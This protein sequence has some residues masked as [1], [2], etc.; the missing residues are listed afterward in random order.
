MERSSYECITSSTRKN[1]LSSRS[2]QRIFTRWFWLSFWR[3]AKDNGSEMKLFAL[4]DV[5][6]GVAPGPW[7]QS[8]ATQAISRFIQHAVGRVDGLALH[9]S[10]SLVIVFIYLFI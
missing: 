5:Y 6:L 8:F 9:T 7:K 4:R 1:C 10:D 3:E 2:G